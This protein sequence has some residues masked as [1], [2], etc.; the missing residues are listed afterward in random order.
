MLPVIQGGVGD[1][2][3]PNPLKDFGP[4]FNQKSRTKIWTQL[5]PIDNATNFITTY[6]KFG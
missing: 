1:D 2:E 5:E 4:K 3:G 6:F